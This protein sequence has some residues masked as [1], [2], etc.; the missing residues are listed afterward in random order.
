MDWTRGF[1]AD[2]FDGDQRTFHYI[3]QRRDYSDYK[4]YTFKEID[5][6]EY[7]PTQE[8]VFLNPDVASE[9]LL[10]QDGLGRTYYFDEFLLSQKEHINVESSIMWFEK[11]APQDSH[12]YYNLLIFLEDY[13]D[14]YIEAVEKYL[15]VFTKYCKFHPSHKEKKLCIDIKLFNGLLNKILYMKRNPHVKHGKY[16]ECLSLLISLCIEKNMYVSNFI[17]VLSNTNSYNINVY[18]TNLLYD[19][20]ILTNNDILRLLLSF[21]IRID[22]FTVL[23]TLDISPMK[24]RMLLPYIHLEDT[25]DFEDIIKDLPA[26]YYM[27]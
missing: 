1:S 22:I 2:D 6:L 17:T 24:F 23:G 21:D 3:K 20:S 8:I 12:H 4:N 10:K 5:E 26:Y 14:K 15:N 25:D 11:Y 27:L 18:I 9:Y 16:I 7:F 19:T 13:P